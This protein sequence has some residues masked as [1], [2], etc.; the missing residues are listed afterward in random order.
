MA[1]GRIVD[2]D[3]QQINDLANL[4]YID[5]QVGQ[6]L[7]NSLCI[8]AVCNVLKQGGGQFKA[9]VSQLAVYSVDHGHIV[10]AQASLGCALLQ[11]AGYKGNRLLILRVLILVVRIGLKDQAQ[12]RGEPCVVLCHRGH[13][14]GHLC[15][16]NG[17]YAVDLFVQRVNG[18]SRHIV[19]VLVHH[20]GQALDQVGQHGDRLAV[21]AVQQL[22]DGGDDGQQAGCAVLYA[23]LCIHAQ[24]K[25]L[26]FF[27]ILKDG[28]EYTV[29]VTGILGQH[30]DQIGDDAQAL[31]EVLE[32][33]GVV[34]CAEAPVDLNVGGA[35][36]AAGALVQANGVVPGRQACQLL[37]G[38][39]VGQVI[40]HCVGRNQALQRSSQNVVVVST[41]LAGVV[42]RLAGLILLLVQL[43]VAVV[44]NIQAQSVL[45]H[46]IVINYILQC[47]IHLNHQI[48]QMILSV[49][50][51]V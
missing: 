32:E 49:N 44:E 9:E 29:I 40:A 23:A 8:L 14:V 24:A 3:F 47:N 10:D 48:G 28:V 45:I 20:N 7:Q 22:A 5:H 30:A 38:G 19:Q 36:P 12:Y 25:A 21:E 50:L 34:A 4:Q 42:H 41:G 6:V 11:Q 16:Q 37:G 2:H 17:G 51:L 27:Q 46:Q 15:A 31:A 18:G 13:Q 35:G 39:L 43:L 26:C 1:Y 33:L